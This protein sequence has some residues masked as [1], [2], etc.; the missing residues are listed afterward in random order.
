M[1]AR[2]RHVL[3]GLVLVLSFS[4]LFP[5]ALSQT[6]QVHGMKA[7]R[8]YKCA[9][10]VS[11]LLFC[12]F[13]VAMLYAYGNDT[14]EGRRRRNFAFSQRSLKGQTFKCVAPQVPGEFVVF[15]V[16]VRKRGVAASRV[17]SL[18]GDVLM[19]ELDTRVRDAEG[20]ID[21]TGSLEALLRAVVL[22]RFPSGH[23]DVVVFQGSDSGPTGLAGGV[24]V[25][26]ADFDLGRKVGCFL[27]DA[28]LG[29]S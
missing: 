7:R 8:A 21:S 22:P 1:S 23:A 14:E 26:A 6:L 17:V 19:V 28:A 10:G 24:A 18:D 29:P 4:A 5:F 2:T 12:C 9:Y 13:A 16:R 20:K 11:L 27:M 25:K 15:P 3:I